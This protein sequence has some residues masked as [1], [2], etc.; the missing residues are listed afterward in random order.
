M[1]DCKVRISGSTAVVTCTRLIQQVK[2]MAVDDHETQQDKKKGKGKAKIH[3]V[4]ETR[5]WE[6]TNGNW[7]L[8]HLHRSGHE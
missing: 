3:S 7:K 6:R 8:T 2:D 5:V 1:S 4:Q